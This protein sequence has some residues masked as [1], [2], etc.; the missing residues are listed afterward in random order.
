VKLESVREILPD[1]MKNNDNNLNC[2]LYV[3]EKEYKV[4]VVV[5]SNV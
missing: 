1:L 2:V 3:L 4:K 5:F